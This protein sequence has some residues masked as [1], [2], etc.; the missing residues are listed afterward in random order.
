[1]QRFSAASMAA[2]AA[3][4]IPDPYSMREVRSFIPRSQISNRCNVDLGVDEVNWHCLSFL[5]TQDET[6][7]DD[8]SDDVD[9]EMDEYSDEDVGGGGRNGQGPEYTEIKEQMYQV[10][11]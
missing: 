4:S 8:E 11:M 10:S 9:D 1:M 5:R 2:A 3:A 7:T 6:S